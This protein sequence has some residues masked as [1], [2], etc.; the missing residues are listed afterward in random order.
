MYIVT[1][2]TLLALSHIDP[3]IAWNVQ[4]S[5]PKLESNEFDATCQHSLYMLLYATCSFCIRCSPFGVPVC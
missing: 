1:F 3:I 4:S 5:L 2:R